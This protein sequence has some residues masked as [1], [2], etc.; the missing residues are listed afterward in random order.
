MA[1]TN[2]KETNKSAAGR[3]AYERELTTDLKDTTPDKPKGIA[4]HTRILIGLIVGVVAGV[5]TYTLFRV[6]DPKVAGS[7]V[8]HPTVEWIVNNFTEPIGTLFLRLLLMIVVP[9]V[10]SSLVV[11]VAGI[12][13]IRQ[14]GAR[15]A[16]VVRLHAR[17]LGHLGGHR[18]DAGEHDPSGRAH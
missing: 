3:D 10:F 7:F 18:P 11:G 14:A 6:P 5:A 15:R 16:E 17:H 9:L 4:L 2:D 12:G 1:D 8:P 13:D